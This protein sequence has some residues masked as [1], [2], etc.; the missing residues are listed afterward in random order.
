MTAKYSPLNVALDHKWA[1]LSKRQT[2]EL[3]PA[4]VFIIL[5]MYCF[6]ISCRRANEGF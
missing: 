2:K 1:G 4:V 6:I 5:G 3:N